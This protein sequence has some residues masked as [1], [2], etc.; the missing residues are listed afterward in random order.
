MFYYPWYLVLAF[1]FGGRLPFVYPFFPVSHAISLLWFMALMVNG[2]A[3]VTV[4]S[5]LL[6]EYKIEM[7]L[8]SIRW[9]TMPWRNWAELRHVMKFL[10]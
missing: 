10:V 8:L 3:D 6:K 5:R 1:V 9:I 4:L 2:M 7:L